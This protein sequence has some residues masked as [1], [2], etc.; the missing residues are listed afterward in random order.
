MFVLAQQA[1]LIETSP[2][3]CAARQGSSGTGV[4][5]PFVV[6]K[7]QPSNGQRRSGVRSAKRGAPLAMDS[8]RI[9]GHWA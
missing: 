7:H 1:Q 4:P 2:K 9:V 6:T 3:V 8:Y 5:D